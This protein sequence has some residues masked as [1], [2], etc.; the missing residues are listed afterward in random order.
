MPDS[1]P[2]GS[3][4]PESS[5]DAASE[6]ATPAVEVQGLEKIYNDEILAVDGI[7]FTVRRATSV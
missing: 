4:A 5:T 2:T 6:Q 1:N 3:V 7:D